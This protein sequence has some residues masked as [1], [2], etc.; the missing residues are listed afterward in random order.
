MESW[1][2]NTD[3]LL[4]VPFLGIGGKKSLSLLFSSDQIK[5]PEAF[6]WPTGKWTNVRILVDKIITRP[7]TV[8]PM[9]FIWDRDREKKRHRP[10]LVWEWSDAKI[11]ASDR[12]PVHCWEAKII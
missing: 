4:F 9:P 11:G 10:S 2:K 8:A 6:Q 7:C 3:I 1:V 12:P 5:W